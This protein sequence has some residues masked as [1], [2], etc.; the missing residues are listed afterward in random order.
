[1]HE[2]DAGNAVAVNPSEIGALPFGQINDPYQK[3]DIKQ[4]HDQGSL[5]TAF[6]AYRAENEVGMLFGNEIVFGLRAFKKTFAHQS[7]RTDGNLRLMHIV[8]RT[9]QVFLHAKQNLD[10]GA[11]MVLQ[12][13][14]KG[15]VDRKDKNEKTSIN[16]DGLQDAAFFRNQ[17]EQNG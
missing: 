4:H 12:D 6:F 8:A 10:T 15:E 1:M 17:A 11:L 14:E 13:L 7:A 5:E 2:N 3:C 16:G 9:F